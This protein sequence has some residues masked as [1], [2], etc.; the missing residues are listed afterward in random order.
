MHDTYPCLHTVPSLSYPI[1][2]YLNFHMATASHPVSPHCVARQRP[3]PNDTTPPYTAR[4]ILSCTEYTFYDPTLIRIQYIWSVYV[5]WI[6][7]GVF[8]AS[9]SVW[10]VLKRF[11]YEETAKAMI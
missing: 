7:V 3:E 6:V 9:A 11:L 5:N 4:C 2:P 10:F 8:L 1:L